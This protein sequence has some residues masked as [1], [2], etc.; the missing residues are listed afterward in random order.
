MN[1]ELLWS[2]IT[3][4]DFFGI[5]AFKPVLA[6]VI[7]LF[8]LLFQGVISKKIIKY[9][10]HLTVKAGYD[11]DD[12]LLELIKKPLNFL[13]IAVA[14]WIIKIILAKDLIFNP[15][16]SALIFLTLI[17]FLVYNAA[18]L[19]GKIL[20]FLTLQTETELDDLL[21]PYIPKLL[22]IAAFV[23]VIIKASE[24]F[25]GASAGALIGLL[26]GAGVA[27]GL[28]F[29]DIIYDWCCTVI[30]YTDGL[31]KPNDWIE[32]S[33]DFVQVV[34]IGLRTTK[35]YSWEWGS[36]KKMPNS[37]MVSGIVDNWSQDKSEIK[38]WGFKGFIKID[39][40]TS[41][42]VEKMLEG[43]KELFGSINGFYPG[44]YKA[45]FMGIEGNARVFRYMAKVDPQYY[46]LALNNFR[47]GLMKLMEKEGIVTQNVH[48]IAD[49]DTYAKNIKMASNN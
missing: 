5:P 30:I 27:L 1:L 13:I 48:I 3:N 31:Y 28:L 4:S 15:Q 7:L 32:V 39:C 11:L 18:P 46:G 44:K 6:F 40:I 42:K 36:I 45:I 9:I 43:M 24:V 25:L 41:D 2:N 35:L 19:L 21:V 34:E 38:E 10:K 20:E 26:G 12:K 17:A 37:R 14:L 22:R 47:L 23:I 29:K 33:G 8:T 16:L 49:Q